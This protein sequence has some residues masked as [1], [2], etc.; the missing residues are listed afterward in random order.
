MVWALGGDTN[1]AC[2]DAADAFGDFVDVC[3]CGGIEEFVRDFF[4][5]DDDSG[6]F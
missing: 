4:L 1:E 5:A 3:D 6:M 2:K